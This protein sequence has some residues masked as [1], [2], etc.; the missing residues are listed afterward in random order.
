MQE[1]NAESTL[2]TKK[3]ESFR[4]NACIFQR[5]IDALAAR[6]QT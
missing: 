3:L 5:I 2:L 6:E 4:V 1:S